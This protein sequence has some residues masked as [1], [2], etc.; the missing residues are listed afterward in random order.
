M[1]RSTSRAGCAGS[2]PGYWCQEF[3]TNYAN[4]HKEPEPDFIEQAIWM[5]IAS[6]CRGLTFWQYK[7]ERFG[8]ESNGWGMREIDGSP[9][10]RSERCDRIAGVLKELGADFAASRPARSKAAIWFDLRNDL[11]MRIEEMRSELNHIEEIRASTDYSCKQAAAADH[12]ILRRLGVTAD[13]VVSGDDLSG[14][15]L[16][17][18]DA[19]RAGRRSGGGVA[20]RIRPG[21][22]DAADRLPVRLPRRTHLGHAAAPRAGTGGPDRLSRNP[23]HRASGPEKSGISAGKTAPCRPPPAGR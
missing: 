5:A 10:R 13:F 8:E 14:C 19:G 6:G 23:P 9:T 17:V 16:L 22:R 3:Y 4:W 7:S 1:R 12:T 15:R 20:D 2:I 21:R 18:A 11:L